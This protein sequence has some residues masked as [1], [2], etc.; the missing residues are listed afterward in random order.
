MYRVLLADDEI[1]DLEGMRTFIPW[2]ELGLEVVDAV[3]NGFAA[4]DVIKNE[5][6]D[7]LVTDVRMPNMSGLEL[8]TKAI[9]K[10]GEL[11]IIF[12]SG[13]QDFNYLKQAI[14]LNAYG[15]VLKPMDD[16]ELIDSL[17]KVRQDLDLKKRRRETEEVYKQMVPI[18][19]NE[20]LLQLLLEIPGERSTSGLLDR[21]YHLDRLSW[22]IRV[23]VLEIDDNS[24]KLNPNADRERKILLDRFYGLLSLLFSEYGIEHVC[25]ISKQRTALLLGDNAGLEAIG[26]LPERIKKEFPFTVTI[27]LGLTCA[28]LHELNVSY[29]QAVKALDDKI[30]HGK[31][32]LIIYD[33]DR[34]GSTDIQDARNLDVQLDAMMTAMSHYELVRIHDELSGLFQITSRMESKVTV[35]NFAM[36]IVMKLNEYL[37]TMN[38]DLFKLFGMELK[39]LD[40][41][42]QFE[43]IDDIHSWLRR[44]V[45]EISEM[46]HLKKHSKNGKLVQNI[47]ESV[48]DRLH[49]N[50]TLR[51]VALR[52]SFSPNYLGHLF[53]GETGQ[54]FSDYIIALRM[55]RAQELL[56]NSKL[57]IYEV[58]N[59]VGYRYLP[60][61][62]RQ[63]KETTGM[64]PLEYRRKH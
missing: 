52:F 54:N 43:T 57:K 56:R 14:K 8:A 6:I 44:R 9:E 49:E 31:G 2:N 28:D 7:I 61:F 40:I 22:P 27:G 5:Q 26:R 64:A 38:E 53:R 23:A 21:E 62:S 15:Y 20:Y 25:K 46:L 1:L 41:L 10:Q 17:T 30:F 51:D 35:H 58:A 59:Q 16:K 48:R 47:M 36:Y 3:N 50:I 4:Y 37:R 55:E 19:K 12:V 24:W 13:Y 63:F 29:G 42:L 60:Y 11:R 33:E 18:V 34:A 45:F 32:K 39:N